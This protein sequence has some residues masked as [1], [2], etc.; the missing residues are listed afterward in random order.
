MI[1]GLESSRRLRPR[2]QG[3]YFW[4]TNTTNVSHLCLYTNFRMTVE[5]P[6]RQVFKVNPWAVL[7]GN[8]YCGR[9]WPV[10][11]A[12]FSKVWIQL[13]LEDSHLQQLARGTAC[14]RDGLVYH[15]AS[16]HVERARSRCEVC[17]CPG[18]V[19]CAISLM[20][21]MAGYHVLDVLMESSRWQPLT[22]KHQFTSSVGRAL[23]LP[24]QNQASTRNRSF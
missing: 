3:I 10:E 24:A 12:A 4:S 21:R 20:C 5:G 8:M 9:T 17:T 11:S 6:Q 18:A 19:L 2:Q 14:S 16:G 13:C 23:I 1:E 7:V 22:G 15:R